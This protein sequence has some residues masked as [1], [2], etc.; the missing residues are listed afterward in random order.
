MAAI[1][2]ALN[3]LNPKFVHVALGTVGYSAGSGSCKLNPGT[4]K[5]STTNPSASGWVPVG[6][7]ATAAWPTY[8]YSALK[9]QLTNSCFRDNN[10][11]TGTWFA[12]PVRAS[13]QYLLG[14]E[15]LPGGNIQSNSTKAIIF[16]T[17]GEPNESSLNWTG[18]NGS[19][20]STNALTT[21]GNVR[22]A[23]N[24]DACT[25]FDTV[26]TAAKLAGVQIA[27]VKYGT[28]SGCNLQTL[29]SPH[30]TTSVPMVFTAATSSDLT[31]VYKDAFAAISSGVRLVSFPQ[32][33]DDLVS[34]TGP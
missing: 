11:G 9:S 25:N 32:P 28:G 29:A 21:P 13:A 31:A 23:T 33:G 5:L 8:D 4:M 3:G 7:P 30:P 19:V 18:S 14:T 20:T 27:F 24:T 12:S 26:A 2:S 22:G 6:L 34:V 15:T 16:Q 17:D 10:S 1:L